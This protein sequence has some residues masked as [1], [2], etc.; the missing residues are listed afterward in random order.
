MAAPYYYKLM[1]Q[2]CWLSPERMLYW[3]EQQT[4]VV[5]DLHFGK[6]GH[7][8]KAGIA[9]P[10]S[11]YREDLQRLVSQLQ[12]FK[13]KRLV[14]VGD[15][16]HSRANKELD[17]F[18]KWRDDFPLLDIQLVM[19]NHDILQQQWYREAGLELHKEALAMAPFL[20]IHDNPEAT[21]SLAEKISA[22]D[23]LPAIQYVF[24]GHLHPGIRVSGAGKQSLQFP[25]FYF[26]SS[27]CVLPAFSRFTGLAMIRPKETDHVFAIVNQSIIQL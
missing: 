12:Y 1:Q 4:L 20:F 3:E 16:F 24:S 14:V 25:C 18:K 7:F 22:A 8:R 10:Q 21:D 13:P 2:N 6:T 19:G 26:T 15:M 9:V 23:K 17:W 5:S 11:V 27:F